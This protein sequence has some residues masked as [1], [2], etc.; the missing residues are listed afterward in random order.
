MMPT[1]L[2][3][4]AITLWGSL[5]LLG[6]M[7]TE[8]PPFQLLFI[9]FSISAG[10]MFLNRLLQKRPVLQKPDMTKRQWLIGIAGLFGFHSCYFMALRFAPAI[11]VSLIV[12]L[13]PLLL[14]L[15][16]ATTG[17]RRRAML[18][19]LLGFIG[20]SLVITQNDN[21]R[22]AIAVEYLGGYALAVC[23]ALIWSTYSWSLSKNAGHS[24]DIGWLSLAVAVLSLVAH[25]IL[26]TS[27]WPLSSKELIGALLLG[28]G[29]VGGAF[30]LWDSGM[31]HGNRSL[32][33]ISS[34]AAPLITAFSLVIAGI[35]EWSLILL[36][37]LI[38]VLTGGL[39]ANPPKVKTA[40]KAEVI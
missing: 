40:A 32:L 22:S 29:P 4:S 36:T 23:C 20:V 24:D 37:A 39:I 12:Y 34:F 6:T 14:T 1:F 28:L 5:A 17:H 8:I 13:W 7:T 18:G 26:E 35:S 31:K 25:L 3:L 10:L 2:G 38:L 15:L 19:G 27:Y 21:G 9:C 33:A 16:V 11:Q 30:Y